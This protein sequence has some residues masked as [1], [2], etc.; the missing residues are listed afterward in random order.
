MPFDFR[1]VKGKKKKHYGFYYMGSKTPK[2]LLQQLLFKLTVSHLTE[3]CT[4][5]SPSAVPI[6]ERYLGR[7]GRE[8]EGGKER[9]KDDF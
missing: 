1:D 7:G 6:K 3:F 2:D 8:E 4:N 9:R 5:I